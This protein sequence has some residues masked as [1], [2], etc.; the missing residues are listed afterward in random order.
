[1]LVLKNHSFFALA[2]ALGSIAFVTGCPSPSPR[3]DVVDAANAGDGDSDASSS[4]DSSTEDVAPIGD[5]A[6]DGPPQPPASEAL[7]AVSV[8]DME[9]RARTHGGFEL[10]VAGRVVLASVWGPVAAQRWNERVET[11]FGNWTFRRSAESEDRPAANGTSMVDGSAL[12][13]RTS[14]NGISS[15]LRFTRPSMDY[16]EV[17][18]SITGAMAAKGTALRF[19]C[20]PDAHFLGFG[21]QYNYVDHRGRRFG[22]FVSEQGLGRD[23]ARPSI[24]SGSP[25]TTYYPLPFFLD[26]R[27]RGMMVETDARTIVDLCR[28]APDEFMFAPEQTE[29]LVARVYTGPTVPD[30][31][32]AWTEY[33]GR[34]MTPPD[35]AVDG[36]WLGVQGGPDALRTYLR[37]AQTANV[38]VTVIWAQ[39]WIGRKDLGLGNVDIRYHWTADSMWYPNL[40]G[41]ISE[42]RMQGVRFLGYFNPFVLMNEDQWAEG[43][44]QGFLPRNSSGGVATFSL[45]H[46]TGT[47]VDLTNPRAVQWFQGFAR[48]AMD[49][50]QVGWMQDYGEWLPLDSV[51]SDGRDAR[52]YH[53]RYPVDWHRAASDALRERYPSGDWVMFSRSGWL[54]DARYSQIVWAGDQEASWGQWDGLPTVVPALV[55]LGMSGVGFVTHD[56]G[57]YFGGP[58]TKELYQRWIELG[59]FTP[60][61]RTHE[62]LQRDRNWNWDRDAETLAFFSRFG[63]VH[64]V[65]GPMFR[66]LGDEHRRTG[67]PIVRAMGLQ[68][69]SDSRM[70]AITDQYMLGDEML[71]APV[72][73]PG[74]TE[75]RVVFPAGTWTSVWDP[76]LTVTGPIERMVP[77]PIGSPPV[78]TRTPRADLRAVR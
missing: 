39:D 62:G 34:T 15:E 27:G 37:T 77:A 72:V 29:P 60:V 32:R 74:Q 1:M 45:A 52:R 4:M 64:Q 53:N 68:F 38:P 57:G 56:I 35:W 25:E 40:A 30:V 41:L 51:L 49:L 42:F 17:R 23:P 3:A 73:T 18:A 75:R 19:R 24:L 43:S 16:V 61:M 9:L 11:A 47:V 6:P 21:E 46:G 28:A 70:Y 54:Q 26:P 67:M 48:Q 78:F 65:L 63:R 59:A 36:V 58:S 7:A 31:M 66:S 5:A 71:V 33:Q 44:T 14:D 2:S 22:L 20:D 69:P 12:V 10:S 8:G 76:T 50:G 13:L 55:S